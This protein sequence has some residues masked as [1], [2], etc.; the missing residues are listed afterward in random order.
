MLISWNVTRACNLKCKH[1]Y[2]DAGKKDPNELT[3][4]EASGLL[5]EI[6][7][8]GF[9][10]IVFSGG[11][12]LLRKD[13][14]ELISYAAKL[15]L[16]PVLGSNGTLIDKK[17]AKMLKDVGLMRAGI[18]LD[19][20]ESQIHDDF[21]QIKG[22]WQKSVEAMHNCQETGLEFQM[23]TTVTRWNFMQVERLIDFA[24][25]V[26][27]SA[28][29]IFFLVPTGRGKDISQVYL[30]PQE[31][32]ELL[33]KI[34]DRQKT[35]PLELRPICAPQFMRI[36]KEKNIALRFQRG[37]LA[38]VSYCCILPNGDV[39]PCPYLPINIGNVRKD[40]FS[41]IWKNAGIFLKLRSL[42][43]GGRCGICEFKSS[44]GG[45]RA[46][47]YWQSSDF[48]QEDK[49][50]VYEPKGAKTLI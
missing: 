13:I 32:E 16:R 48:M 7:C 37:C 11:E 18:S 46:N 42:D 21:R 24:C 49:T 25:E 2:R 34:L 12:P 27:A 22:S 29:H 9:K 33:H 1:C 43:Y 47:A 23:H 30:T 4:Q 36:A 44:C 20:V 14:Y 39:H 40:K 35:V 50:C 10:I 31:H 41:S 5:D 15:G 45:C 38:G 26:G 19:S 6:S 3:T 8:A 17:T 28:Y